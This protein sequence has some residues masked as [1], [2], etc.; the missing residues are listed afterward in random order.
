M[1]VDP[2]K[3]LALWSL[4]NAYS[5]IAFMTPDQVEA[6]VY[7]DKASQ[8]FQRAVDE[9]NFSNL[10]HTPMLGLHVFKG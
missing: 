9:V 1:A 3:H 8:Y 10:M 7:F 6:K 4:G 2:K 5:S